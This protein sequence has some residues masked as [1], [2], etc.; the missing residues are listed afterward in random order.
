MKHIAVDDDHAYLP[1]A[2]L[3]HFPKNHKVNNGTRI[4]ILQHRS[5]LECVQKVVS[6]NNDIIGLQAA[7]F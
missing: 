7:E 4:P 5:S 1:A 3:A 2:V 6:F